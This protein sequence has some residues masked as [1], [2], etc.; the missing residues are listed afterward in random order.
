MNTLAYNHNTQEAMDAAL[1]KD[2]INLAFQ[3]K[4]DLRHPVTDSGSLSRR[5]DAID[6]VLARLA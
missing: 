1:L 4:N 2:L 5:L 6:S 3:Y